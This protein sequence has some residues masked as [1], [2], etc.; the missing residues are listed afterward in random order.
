MVPTNGRQLIQK[1]N[2]FEPTL[3]FC[4]LGIE[5]NDKPNE[6]LLLK[7][8]VLAMSSLPPISQVFSF[9]QHF[10]C[11]D[12]YMIFLSL[13]VPVWLCRS[14]VLRKMIMCL[15]SAEIINI[16]LDCLLQFSSCLLR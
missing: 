5:A 4:S 15:T 10:I 12:A 8:I 14:A 1:P 3:C 11:V 2:N 9:F 7:S 16:K 13:N 6:V